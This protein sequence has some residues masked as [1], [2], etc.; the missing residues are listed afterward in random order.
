MKK[1]VEVEY[2]GIEDMQD[3]LDD[4]YALQRE[5][6]Y[7]SF[8]MANI[9][10]CTKVSIQIMLDGWTLNRSYDYEY[11]FY[12][13]DKSMDVKQMNDCKNALKNLLTGE[14]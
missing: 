1:I 9:S 14:E 4:V 12:V 2:V 7:V 5:G 6:H 10:D 11:A 8:E 13:T 3:I